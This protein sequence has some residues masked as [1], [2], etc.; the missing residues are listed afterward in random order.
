MIFNIAAT[1]SAIAAGQNRA[2]AEGRKMAFNFFQAAAGMFQYINDNFLHAP[3]QDLSR[4][5]VKMLT[6]LM[7]AQAHECFLE[8][9][10]REKKKDGLIAKLGSHAAWTYENI[11]YELQDS[12][13]RGVGIDKAWITVCQI[14]QK[15]YQ[16]L[17]QEHRAAVCEA[18]QQYGEQVARLKAA[19]NFGKEATKLCSSLNS[20]LQSSNY[21]NGT[22]PSDSGSALQELVKAMA[23][24][25]SEKHAAATRDNDM[26][27]HDAVPQESILTPIDRLKAVKPTQISDL[28]GQNEIGKVIGADIFAR[29][30]PLSVHES[31]SMYSEEKAKML[32]GET[33]RC[34]MAKAELNT[35]L[36]YMK[37]PGSLDKFRQQEDRSIDELMVP[38][39][40]ARDWAEQIAL[41]ESANRTS[42]RELIDTLDGFKRDATKKLDESSMNLDQEIRECENMRVSIKINQG[43]K[44]CTTH[45]IIDSRSNLERIGAN[46]LLAI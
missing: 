33:E 32:R 41:E 19:E 27:Y 28:Y 2:E 13:G 17:A 45:L 35:A 26:I 14:K 4:E 30:V 3:S 25:C 40:D 16:A 22:L 24:S 1:L 37:L 11:V 8:S 44:S 10:L 42:L 12:V 18:E 39:K 9:S 43:S 34:D 20:Q 6:E 46:S 29:L 38:T 31:A 21:A 15:Y 23:A 5:T 7:L 36:E